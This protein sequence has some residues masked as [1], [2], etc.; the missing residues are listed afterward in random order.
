MCTAPKVST[1]PPAPP[2]P[3]AVPQ[4]SI[5]PPSIRSTTRITRGA[6]SLTIAGRQQLQQRRNALAVRRQ[7]RIGTRAQAVP[8]LAVTPAQIAARVS[9]RRRAAAPQGRSVAPGAQPASQAELQ[10]QRLAA[11]TSTSRQPENSRFPTIAIPTPP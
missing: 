11:Q 6:R 2:R 1:P 3:P 8:R 4:Q 7:T 5:A 10:R 9:R